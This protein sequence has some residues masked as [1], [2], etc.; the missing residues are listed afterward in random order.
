[1]ESLLL[2]RTIMILKRYALIAVWKSGKQN[3]VVFVHYDHI[4][5][6]IKFAKGTNVDDGLIIGKQKKLS[7]IHVNLQIYAVIMF[8]IS[9]ISRKKMIVF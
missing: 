6:R 2:I 1:M 3:L 8:N 7:I 4:K 9:V 5:G